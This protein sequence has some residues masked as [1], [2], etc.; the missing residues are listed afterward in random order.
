M[1]FLYGGSGV[2]CTDRLPAMI[3]DWSRL[4]YVVEV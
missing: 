1:L 3:S 2:E 4:V